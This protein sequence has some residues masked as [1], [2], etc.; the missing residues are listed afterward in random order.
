[1]NKVVELQDLNGLFK[2]NLTIML[3]GF[4]DCGTA[5]TVLNYVNELKIK[6]LT[7][8]VNDAGFTQKS[9]GN[10]LANTDIDKLITSH[11]GTNPEVGNKMTRGEIEVELIPQGNLIEQIR[12]KGAGLGGVLTPTGV[13]TLA[14]EGK[15]VMEVDGKK[16]ILA[17]PLGADIAIIKAWQADES[18]NLI[19]RYSA[20]NFNPVMAM[21]ADTVIVEA[22][23]I[24]KNGELENN[25]IDTPNIFVDYIIESDKDLL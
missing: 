8:I 15:K 19:Y 1:M 11:I 22:E 7:I 24:V 20:Q 14:E 6:N 16:Y 12:C 9:K 13:G 4:L 25:N 5:E 18:G 21:A 2:D 10:F 17:T 3:G 23:Q